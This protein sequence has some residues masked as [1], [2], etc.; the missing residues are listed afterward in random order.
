MMQ[1]H[2]A[3]KIAAQTRE[4]YPQG[5]PGFGT[6]ALRFTFAALASTGRDI[7][8]DLGRIEGY[9]NF[10]NKLW[11]AARYVL[12][13]TEGQ[14]CGQAGGEIQLSAADL[15]IRSRL[16]STIR[17]V[18]EAFEGY[19]FDHAARAVYEFTWNELC[20]WYLELSKPVLTS[21]DASTGAKRGTRRTLVR[22]LES[23]LRLAHPVMPFI[24]EEIWQKV[25]PLAGAEGETIM[26]AP[27]PI[28]DQ[29]LIDERAVA[30]MGWVMQFILGVRRIRGEMNIPPGRP[31]PVLLQHCSPRDREWLETARPYLDFL[32]RIES[33]D[34]LP[35]EAQAPES[36]IA[37]VGEMKVL[38]PMSGLIDKQA[39]L[40]RL[41]KEI[42]RLRA[43][44]ERT[45]KKLANPSFVDKAP[46][47]VV[48]KERD[49]LSEQ[50]AAIGKLEE[51]ERKIRSL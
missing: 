5:I 16:Q 35:G 46:P 13:N 40:T 42:G 28:A 51:Q 26:L 2:L 22:T 21:D 15:W 31:L 14:D 1:P 36:A 12:M 8:F 4:D 9:R 41:G 23:L 44:L 38:I 39:E 17:A 50:R 25:K 47:A 30:E 45:G 24:T 37:L 18:T 29:S 32:A 48:Q 20:D 11:N 34:I 19:R 33:I 27:F 3:E 7:K 10:C 43:D 6:D 49:K